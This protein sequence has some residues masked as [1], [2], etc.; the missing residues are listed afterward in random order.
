MTTRAPAPEVG[1]LPPAPPARRAAL[2]R[3][4]GGAVAA[5]L[6]ALVVLGF[7]LSV[8]PARDFTVP[9]GWDES[10][11]LWRARLALEVGVDA[12]DRP[13]PAVPSPKS[14]RPGFPVVAAVLSSLGSVSPFRVAMVLSTVMAAAIGLAASGLVGTVLRRPLWEQAAVGL[15]VALSPLMV[16]LM[17]PES[18][19]DTMLAA[20][21]FTAA[22][23]PVALA[24]EDRRALLPAVLLVGAGAAIHWSFFG[25][26]AVTLLLTGALLLPRSWARWRRGETGLLDTPTARLGQVLVG[27]AAVGAVAIFGLLGDRL[28]RPRLDPSELA[29]KLRR[30]LPK[31]RFAFTLPVA[32]LGAAWL[33]WAGRRRDDAVP[34]AAHA[35][36]PPGRARFVLVWFLAWCA[37]VA[38]GVGA[39][40][41]LGLNV[42]AHRFL[43]FAL[44]LP[45]L[46]VLGVVWAGRLLSRGLRAPVAVLLV[47]AALAG[48]G[49]LAHRQWFGTRTWTDPEVLQDVG[50]AAGYLEAAGVPPDRPVVFVVST[51][52]WNTAGL[53]GHMVRAALPPER[54]PRAYLFVGRPQDYLARRPSDWA[55]SRASFERLRRILPERPVAVAV[56]MPRATSLA[57]TQTHP[58]LLITERV[59]V[60]EG[61]APPPGLRPAGPPVGGIPFWKLAA[62]A[63]GSLL[64]LG[65]VGL[66]WAWALLRPWAEPPQALA[67]APAVGVGIL[68]LGGVLTDRLG[69]RLE[70]AV[71]AAL[72][73][74]L[75]GGGA[76]LA[77]A[78]RGRA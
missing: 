32:A 16:R 57:W 21:V 44:P 59:A 10:E 37:V 64:A 66:G 71:G 27:G 19:M 70:G 67:L 2:A 14:G 65:L 49:L 43:S 52:D 5:G 22:A 33:W 51:R 30:D 76:L 72:P 18:Y 38:G 24:V 3:W 6:V 7:Y 63:G 55:V 58:D 23:V 56:A 13:L 46:G 12:I 61:P 20:A 60:V 68:V 62:I 11:Y 42:P 40:A 8:Y 41:L 39:R 26:L 50:V 74:I 15:G 73:L 1:R 47:A 77:G 53:L 31:Y 4:A 69:F 29:K 78:R 34:E 25:F 17:S 75:A 54:I 9:I 48:A 36:T 35:S 45:I 28:P